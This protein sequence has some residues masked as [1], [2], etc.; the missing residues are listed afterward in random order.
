MSFVH[1]LL[2]GGLVL[3][4]VPIL[5]HLIM[6]QKPKHLIFPAFRFLQQKLT[7]TRRKLQL[8]HL[9]LLLLR[10]LLIA[11]MC[12]A[13]AR[14]KLF[15]E[16]LSLTADS[17]VFVVMLFDTSPSMEY[18]V[19]HK[20]RL[21][22]AKVRAREW[23][24]DL[25]DGSK[26]AVFDS[27]D[28]GGEW[29]P[30]IAAAR[31]QV[32]KLQVRPGNAPLT[33]QIS[34][35]YRLLESASRD[36]DTGDEPP[37]LLYVFSDR[38]RACWDDNEARS[39]TPPQ[40]VAALFLDVGV[41]KPVDVAISGLEL[42]HEVLAAGTRLSIRVTVKATGQD[43]DT[44]VVCRVDEET[45]GESKP[46][47]VM[48]GGTAGVTFERETSRLATG[49]HRVEVKLGT[50][51]ALPFDDV[52]FATFEIRSPRK[53]L[54]LTDRPTKWKGPPDFTKDPEEVGDDYPWWVAVESNVQKSL[55]RCEV[56]PSSSAGALDPER[57][58]GDY[59]AVCLID[60]AEP[61][62]GLWNVLDAYV[63]RGGKLAIVPGPD[64]KPERYNEAANLMPAKLLRPITT[65]KQDAAVPWD[66]N[67]AGRPHSLLAPF[68]DLKQGADVDFF[69]EALLPRVVRYWEVE[70]DSGVIVHYDD[71]ERKARPPALVERQVGQGRVLLFT[72]GMDGRR[73]RNDNWYWN[74]YLASSFYLLLVDNS[75][76]YLVG[77][78]ERPSLNRTCGETVQLELPA[79]PYY[80]L[81]T[82]Q[83]PG[84][85]GTAVNVRRPAE[86]NTVAVGQA[87][88]P[89]NYTLFDTAATPRPVAGFTLNV[90]A[91]EC[92]LDRVE[93][94]KIVA[95]LG[96][97]RLVS[98]EGAGNLREAL[99]GLQKQPI[100][101]LPWLMI[102]L[103]LLL[104]G[105]NLLANK[106]YRGEG[107]GP[108]AAGVE[109]WWAFLG[110][111]TRV[112][113]GAGAGAAAAAAIGVM[114]TGFSSGSSTLL[115]M[116][117]AC[118]VLGGLV[119]LRS[120]LRRRKTVQGPE[121]EH[122]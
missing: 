59:K 17:P 69:K 3:I 9:L 35:A 118:A 68:L 30:S 2:L 1:P 27:A 106:F 116:V 119:G 100:E 28:L 93:A 88:T 102:V 108:A 37:R 48:A 111:A 95:L 89:G 103:L 84:L 13:L 83:G 121:A 113:V 71:H 34:Q 22:E 85:A 44:F 26:V 115:L 98:L 24:A 56:K 38:T 54:V 16:R 31:D 62:A 33:R 45:P 50:T 25:P 36:H 14:P 8:R 66:W 76:R 109:R 55:F 51:D 122:A 75:L 63:S 32:E 5:I 43:V 42:S 7:T 82:L 53:V 29:A 15:S 105:E 18:T 101:M 78:L 65:E 80:P 49:T 117:L 6:K 52:R 90:K 21:E 79:T 46:V 41:D 60:V 87:V 86:Q 72:T 61:D 92:D 91:D 120:G 23:L 10:I 104:A 19:N 112:L 47:Q 110:L 11:L 114:T 20:G 81:Y 58:L 39:L 74:N 99:K 96:S 57:L 94:E 64:L 73:D 4:G 67:L 70:A 77:D 97:D 40:T 12:L 107:A